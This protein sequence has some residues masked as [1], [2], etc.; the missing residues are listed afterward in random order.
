MKVG[1]IL[2]YLEELAPVSLAESW[3][4]VGLI[5]GQKDK[6]ANKVL[7]ALDLNEEVCD[8]AISENVD[9]IVTHHPFLFI[10]IKN[11]I[12]DNSKGRIIEKLIKNDISVISMHT[13]LDSSKKGINEFIAKKLDI[14][15]SCVL[16]NN[17]MEEGLGRYGEIE[18]LQI[19]EL[20]KKVKSIFNIE[21]VRVAGNMNNTDIIT[22]IAVCSGDGASLIDKASE[23]AQVYITGDIKFHDAQKSYERGFIIIDAGHYASE[24]IIIPVLTEYLNKYVKTISSK[25]N[26]EVFRL[27]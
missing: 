4:N 16:H 1:D 24:Q 12:F 2:S 5:L 25:V 6:E 11:I 18:P 8:E 22:T 26:G 23:V 14:K 20:I 27:M 19:G 21:Y 13:N 17:E 15:N 10:A 9:C 7:C 3:D